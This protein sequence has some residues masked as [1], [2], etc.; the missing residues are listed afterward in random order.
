MASE[1]ETDLSDVHHPEWDIGRTKNRRAYSKILGDMLGNRM[2]GQQ[3]RQVAYDRIAGQTRS[4]EDAYRDMGTQAYGFNNPSGMTSALVAQTRAKAPYA[5]ADLAAR[6][7]GRQSSINTGRAILDKQQ[8]HANLYSTVIAP[9]LQNKEI[10]NQAALG[11]AQMAA[12]GSAGG[13]AGGSS[14]SWLGPAI[15]G[16][17][18]IASAAIMTGLI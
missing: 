4:A 2:A 3:Y 12:M 9:Y 16:V 15:G 13:A 5:A 7:A 14:N 6:E 11:L 18:Q 8:Q 10:E 1:L 17:G